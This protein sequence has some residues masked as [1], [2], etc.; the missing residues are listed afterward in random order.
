MEQIGMLFGHPAM[1]PRI[2]FQATIFFASAP[3][4]FSDR[5]P[6]NGEFPKIH[7][8]PSGAFANGHTNRQ[9]SH[10][11]AKAGTTENA[12][13]TRRKSRTVSFVVKDFPSSS[14]TSGGRT[15][16]D[17]LQSYTTAN[18]TAAAAAAA[19]VYRYDHP[20]SFSHEPPRHDSHAGTAA[21]AYASTATAALVTV[22]GHTPASH[23]V[24]THIM[25]PT[26][27]AASNFRNPLSDNF[28]SID[29]VCAFRSVFRHLLSE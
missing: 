11:A 9:A 1:N 3:F 15:A 5:S 20:A 10:P 4:C 2:G 13:H 25:A 24:H 21:A 19:T 27:I 28:I 14:E 18:K 23:I 26:N 22:G 6:E 7:F 17:G 29:R 16:A 12:A 8:L